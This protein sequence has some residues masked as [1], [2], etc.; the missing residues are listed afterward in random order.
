MKCNELV[1]PTSYDDLIEIIKESN[2]ENKKIHVLGLGKHHVRESEFDICVS[3]ELLNSILESSISDLYVTV[4]SGVTTKELQ[5]YLSEKNLFFPSSYD[6]TIGGL[7]S[8][9][10]PSPFSIWFPYPKDLI[11]GAKIITGDGKLIKSG[12]KTTKFSS[13]YKIWK[14][15]AGTLGTLG[16]YVELN[17]KVLPKPEKIVSLKVDRPEEV[18][19]ENP[20]GIVSTLGSSGVTHYAIFAGF[21][22]Y[23]ERISKN[24]ES[25]EG[26]IHTE[27]E[28]ERVFG[29]VVSRG[30]EVQV[31]EKLSSGVAFYGSGYIRTCDERALSLRDKGYTVIIER[32]CRENEDCLGY[33]YTSLQILKNSLDPNHVLCS[34]IAFDC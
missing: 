34:G 15:L 24:R 18:L 5:A 8:T 29:I 9:N 3:T 26:V 32:G 16:V 20:W 11:L 6:G 22:T 10:F 2:K 19:Y 12:S 28:C 17:L 1:K 30:A 21:S 25:V 7:L 14:T 23:I 4:Q 27:L 13:G 33:S 31:L